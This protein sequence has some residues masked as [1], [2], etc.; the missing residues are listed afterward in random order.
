[1]ERAELTQQRLEDAS[2]VDRTWIGKL[3]TDPDANPTIDT[4][5]KLDTAL[6]SLGALRRGEKLVFGSRE[7]VA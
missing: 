2:G 6:R 4:Y 5:D 3:K 7:A 1:M